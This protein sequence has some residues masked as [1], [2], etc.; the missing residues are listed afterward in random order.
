M[1]IIRLCRAAPPSCG[2]ES[3]AQSTF[4]VVWLA[5]LGAPIGNDGVSVDIGGGSIVLAVSDCNIV[6]VAID[7][8]F[9]QR[10]EIWLRIELFVKVR[11]YNRIESAERNKM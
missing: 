9:G 5:I 6:K 10:K 7:I 11:I 3:C 8:A 2:T 1:K 4:I